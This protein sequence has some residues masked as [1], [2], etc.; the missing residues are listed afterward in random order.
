M[1]TV[2][3][4]MV[5]V[6]LWSG[7]F[8]L[9]HHRISDGFDILRWEIVTIP[10]KLLFRIGEPLRDDPAV[11]YAV[12]R[13]F[14]L[15]ERSDYEGIR[16]ENIVESVIEVQLD[17]VLRSERIV[18]WPGLSGKLGVW[19]PV[20]VELA[21]A[22]RVLVVSPRSRIERL[23]TTLL[24]PELTLNAAIAMEERT[25]SEDSSIAALIVGIGGLS[26]YPAI[27]D[28]GRSY[29]ATV[30]TAAHEWTHHYLAFHTLGFGVPSGDRLTINETVADIV[31]EELTILL[32]ERF[33]D[34]T[35][36]TGRDGSTQI[37]GSENT[38]DRGRGL[39]DLR[40]EVDELL[41]TD[42]VEMAE[43]R[44][45]EVRIELQ[46]AGIYIR[47]INQAYF[48]WIGNYAA[49]SDTVDTL[50]MQLR[51]IRR[52]AGS[53]GEFLHQIGGIKSRVGVERLLQD[54]DDR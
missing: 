27:L 16:L 7:L 22:P 40:L 5:S 47:R 32:I 37:G 21:P 18:G 44:M 49:R 43:R 52:N 25:E 11:P 8:M 29:R 34:P 17:A 6:V 41:A 36:L 14:A 2:L 12:S 39:R 31:A 33:G 9:R 19:P 23:R 35:D 13:Y 24:N 28:N 20:D 45:E 4:G 15:T 53:V 48:A 51:E 38:V 42:N 26:T 50:G 3:V 54:A 10:N 30:S 46:D 1:I